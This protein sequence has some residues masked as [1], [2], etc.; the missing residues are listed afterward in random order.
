[1]RITKLHF[2]TQKHCS[3]IFLQS[4]LENGLKSLR[5]ALKNFKYWVSQKIIISMPPH[6]DN[7]HISRKI[8]TAL[9]IFPTRNVGQ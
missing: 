2:T 3:W 8:T 1:M 9:N 6:E 5:S 7:T 4:D